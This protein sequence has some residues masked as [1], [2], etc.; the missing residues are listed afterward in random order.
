MQKTRNV[1]ILDLC[2]GLIQKG[3]KQGLFL[4]MDGQAGTHN[5]SKDAVR[6]TRSS[7]RLLLSVAST[8]STLN[9]LFHI[10]KFILQPAD[11][12]TEPLGIRLCNTTL[13]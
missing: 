9:S 1:L 2:H 5:D 13:F 12:D 7:V 6:T 3:K 11:A 10:K 8:A 4:T